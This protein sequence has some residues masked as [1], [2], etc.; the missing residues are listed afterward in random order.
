M[1]ENKVRRENNINKQ[2]SYKKYQVIEVRVS[3]WFVASNDLLKY[4]NTRSSF[5]FP[6]LWVWIQSL[7]HIKCFSS[8]IEL[9]HL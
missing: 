9:T 7:Q 6:I 4:S 8:I 1:T 3:P 2:Q 5:T